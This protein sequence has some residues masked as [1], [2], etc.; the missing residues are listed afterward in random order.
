LAKDEVENGNL[1]N[2]PKKRDFRF[3]QKNFFQVSQ[4]EKLAQGHLAE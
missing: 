1:N 4:V 2:N 3:F